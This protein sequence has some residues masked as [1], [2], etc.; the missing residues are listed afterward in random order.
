MLYEVITNI[1]ISKANL[2][3]LRR[4]ATEILSSKRLAPNKYTLKS[5]QDHSPAPLPSPFKISCTARTK[6]Q[7]ME[8]LEYPDIRIYTT[9]YDLYAEY[10][11]K[12][13]I[14]YILQPLSENTTEYSYNFV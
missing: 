5:V 6:K 8:L 4:D 2:N 10:K 1:F 11:N 7:L 3:K 12:T 14:Y 9:E 13:D